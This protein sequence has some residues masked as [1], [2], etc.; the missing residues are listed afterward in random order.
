MKRKPASHRL[1]HR[2]ALESYEPRQLLSAVPTIDPESQFVGQMFQTQLTSATI[3]T[4]DGASGLAPVRVTAGADSQ[5]ARA[6]V[7]DAEVVPL[8]VA[9]A[10][11]GSNGIPASYPGVYPVS[12]DVEVQN[13]GS[14]SWQ[15]VQSPILDPISSPPQS[16]APT[17][18]LSESEAVNSPVP[19]QPRAPIVTV[20]LTSSPIAVTVT[21]MAPTT[22]SAAVSLVTLT[23]N[24]TGASPR[25]LSATFS[26]VEMYRLDASTESSGREEATT[27]AGPQDR[28]SLQ[29]TRVTAQTFCMVSVLPLP[30]PDDAGPRVPKSVGELE[31][32][33]P[34]T[35]GQPQPGDKV[36]IQP[37]EEAGHRAARDAAILSLTSWRRPA[38]QFGLPTAGTSV[39]PV[40][41]DTSDDGQE[42]VDGEQ[43]ERWSLAAEFLVEEK[44][45]VG[46]LLAVIAVKSLHAMERADSS[47]TP[48]LRM[49]LVGRHKPLTA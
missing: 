23:T 34:T 39:S 38:A 33:T 19:A 12:P 43:P 45:L 21:P 46:A 44:Q 26:Q 6:I 8:G 37:A 20:G 17:G 25:W 35:P 1:R 27:A 7:F 3:I 47:Q 48:R 16:L 4:I 15:R 24:N 14:L 32:N 5:I 10:W 18:S 2:F 22:E 40:R 30:A 28:L 41:E 13:P 31:T 11:V 49:R 29:P 36:H 9:N 42:L